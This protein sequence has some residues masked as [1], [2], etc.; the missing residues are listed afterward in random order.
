MLTPFDRPPCQAIYDA[1]APR[2]PGPLLRATLAVLASGTILTL[3]LIDADA[4]AAMAQVP[5]VSARIA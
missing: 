1:P 5:A 4:G 3:S 2:M